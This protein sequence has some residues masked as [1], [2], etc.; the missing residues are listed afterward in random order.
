MDY[1]KYSVSR[2]D[3]QSWL[4]FNLGALESCGHRIFNYSGQDEEFASFPTG[5]R[6]TER[7]SADPLPQV[8]RALS[9]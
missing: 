7:W 8:E 2:R 3:V 6:R 5:Q 1:K 9:L 4:E